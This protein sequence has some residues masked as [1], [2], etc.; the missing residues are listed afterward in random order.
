MN[1]KVLSNAALTNLFSCLNLFQPDVVENSTLI[2]CLPNPAQDH[3]NV[4][5]TLPGEQTKNML[6]SN[7]LGV[8]VKQMDNLPAKGN[9]S[10]S[11]EGG[12]Q[13]VFILF[14]FLKGKTGVRNKILI[15]K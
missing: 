2:S 15:S 12:L 8:A 4:F 14:H 1:A 7:S 10:L 9:V 3:L 6:L 11:T 5:Y 13:R